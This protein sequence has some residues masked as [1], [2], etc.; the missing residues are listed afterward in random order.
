MSSKYEG[1]RFKETVFRVSSEE[2]AERKLT[3]QIA[4]E[5]AR[6]EQVKLDAQLN[7]INEVEELTA[8]LRSGIYYGPDGNDKYAEDL[9]KVVDAE[10]R[11]LQVTNDH[12]Q[13]RKNRDR[14]LKVSASY[15]VSNLSNE[16]NSGSY[17][18]LLMFLLIT[19]PFH[20]SKLACPAHPS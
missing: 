5:K 8:N 16:T 7:Y 15:A 12:T 9:Q 1:F 20:H 18:P 6:V 14:R 17:A 19:T 4:Q 2:V 10:S 13:H 3:L 11:A